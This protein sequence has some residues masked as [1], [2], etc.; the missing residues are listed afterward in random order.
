[1][2]LTGFVNALLLY[3]FCVLISRFD[4]TFAMYFFLVESLMHVLYTLI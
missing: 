1:M 2:L 4:T 3:N